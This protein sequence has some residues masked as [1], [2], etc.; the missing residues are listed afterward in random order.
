MRWVFLLIGGG[1]EKVHLACTLIQSFQNQEELSRALRPSFLRQMKTDMI[2][3]R[4][5]S[6]F[7]AE[8][9]RQPG[10]PLCSAVQCSAVQCSAVQCSAFSGFRYKTQSRRKV[11]GAWMNFMGSKSDDGRACSQC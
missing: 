8:L 10:R 1:N 4:K 2:D 9:V 7:V 11:Y 3:N 6:P 5:R